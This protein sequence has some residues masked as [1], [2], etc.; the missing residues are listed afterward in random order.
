MLI[1]RAEASDV[2]AICRVDAGAFGEGP[3]A[4]VK[5]TEGDPAWRQ[6]RFDRLYQWYREHYAETFVAVVDGKVIGFAGYKPFEGTEGMIHNN[7]VDAEY[8]GRG[9]S[10]ALLARVI[11]E[12]K[13]LGAKTIKVHTAHVPVAVHVYQKV[14]FKIVEQRGALNILELNVLDA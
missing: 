8:R 7:A 14:G 6:R 2:D 9:I 1:R 11:D 10:P 4:A 13:S 5:D 12:L 3:Y